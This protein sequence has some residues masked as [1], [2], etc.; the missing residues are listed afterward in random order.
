MGKKLAFSTNI[1]V[2]DIKLPD[3][4]QVEHWDKSTPG[5]CIRAGRTAKSFVF[6]YRYDG[7]QRRETLGRYNENAPALN[8]ALPE[9][10]KGR[11]LTLKAA[12]RVADHIQTMAAAGKDPR[13]E[14]ADAVAEQRRITEYTYEKAV[15]DFYKEYLTD[16]KQNVTRDAQRARLLRIA[17]DEQNGKSRWLNRPVAEITLADVRADLKACMAKEWRVEA[18]HRHAIL[19]VFFKWLRVEGLVPENIMGN[20]PRPAQYTPKKMPAWT[21][22]EIS[23]LWKCAGNLDVRPGAYL[24]L[25]ML[26]GQ[27][28]NEVGGMRWDELNLDIGTT[29]VWPDSGESMANTWTLLPPRHKAGHHSGRTKVFGLPSEAVRIL[30]SLEKVEGSPFVF[31]G[32]TKDDGRPWTR[33]GNPRPATVRSTLQGRIQEQSGVEHFTFQN[34][35]RTMRTG[36]SRLAIPPHIKDACLNHAPRST[37]DKHYD[38]YQYIAEQR[39]AFEAW[40]KHIEQLVYPEG[41][42]GLH[43]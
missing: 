19:S 16:N 4:G 8:G 7:H 18:N 20:V 22:E 6:F 33:D 29:E 15:E 32:R 17:R 23:A 42:V 14:Q 40:A 24:H 36:L 26:L 34:A 9:W 38:S 30:N 25:L 35:R 10:G 31:P 2:R 37:G 39:G 27:R 3:A 1:Q 28:P 41:V 13:K 11:P 43:G 21:S 12:R 5:L